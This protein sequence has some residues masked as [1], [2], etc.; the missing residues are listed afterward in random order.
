MKKRLCGARLKNNNKKI[1]I[2]IKK[3]SRTSRTEG[4]FSFFFFFFL[5]VRGGSPGFLKN[6]TRK[7]PGPARVYQIQTHIRKQKKKKNT[8]NR[9]GPS[10]AGRGGSAVFCTVLLLRLVL[11]RRPMILLMG[12]SE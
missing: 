3:R 9:L 7:S 5:V 10:R 12:Q 4:F 6:P 2:K 11:T 8:E 1:K